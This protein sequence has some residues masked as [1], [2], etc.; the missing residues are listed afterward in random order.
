[1]EAGLGD[2]CRCE[3][4]EIAYPIEPASN[5]NRRPAHAHRL[6][7]PKLGDNISLQGRQRNELSDFRMRGIEPKLARNESPNARSSGGINDEILMPYTIARDG[8]YDGI[9]SLK[10]ARERGGAGEVCSADWDV[11]RKGGGGRFSSK[12]GDIEGGGGKKGG[13]DMRPEIA[14][15]LD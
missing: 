7:L 12:D 14:G 5:A 10:R 11:G 9:L 8:S 3:G 4:S 1:M 6:F 13:D 15:C 2:E